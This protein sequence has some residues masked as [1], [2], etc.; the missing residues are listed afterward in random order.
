MFISMHTEKA[1]DKNPTSFLDKNSEQIRQGRN[2]P[3]HNKQCK[4]TSSEWINSLSIRPKTL[5]LLVESRGASEHW[6][7]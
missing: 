3:S 6:N 2:V 1:F 7:G 4:N 5:K